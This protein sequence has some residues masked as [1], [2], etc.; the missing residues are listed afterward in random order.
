MQGRRVLSE[1]GV[2]STD[3]HRSSH[4]SR[5]ASTSRLHMIDGAFRTDKQEGGGEDAWPYTRVDHLS[6][7]RGGCGGCPLPG[8]DFTQDADRC[9]RG[10]HVSWR[11]GY[12]QLGSQGGRAKGATTTSRQGGRQRPWVR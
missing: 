10:W 12:G 6:R 1:G 9:H 8:P 3:P 11:D 2:V 5:R 7:L 4:P